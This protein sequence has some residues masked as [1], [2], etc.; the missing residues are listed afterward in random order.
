MER[1]REGS[2]ELSSLSDFKHVR[3]DKKILNDYLVGRYDGIPDLV[4]S[5][6]NIFSNEPEKGGE[7]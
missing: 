1:N 4:F 7:E 5:A 2:S 3:K 6:N